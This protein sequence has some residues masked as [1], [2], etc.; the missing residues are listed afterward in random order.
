MERK[1]DDG[2]PHH[3]DATIR[4]ARK[5]DDTIGSPNWREQDEGKR[6]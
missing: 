1:P 4:G 5:V 2:K 6:R 3:T